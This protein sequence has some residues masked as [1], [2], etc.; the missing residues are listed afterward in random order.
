MLS[1]AR[2]LRENKQTPASA[3][4]QKRGAEAFRRALA[5][6]NGMVDLEELRQNRK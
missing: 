3:N 1:Y 5:R 2:V 4:W 6:D